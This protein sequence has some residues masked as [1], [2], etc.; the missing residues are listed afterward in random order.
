MFCLLLCLTT[1][2]NLNNGLPIVKNQ[3]YWV[4]GLCPSS[5]FINTTKEH[6]VSETGSISVIR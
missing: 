5:S 3:D 6:N 1:I 4:F 2:F